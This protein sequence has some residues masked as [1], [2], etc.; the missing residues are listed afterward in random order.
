MTT[1]SSRAY[2]LKL[3]DDGIKLFL[4]C[5]GR[6]CLLVP[7]LLSY[8][9]T[10]YVSVA[11]LSH[12]STEDLIAEVSAEDL[13][14]FGGKEIRFVGTSTQLAQATARLSE[15]IGAS[16]HL[17]PV[18]QSWKIFLAALRAMQSADDK[19]IVRTYDALCASDT[20]MKPRR[21]I[22]AS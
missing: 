11:A 7:E 12:S 14:G 3:S 1:T 6:L 20:G 13:L 21:L 10:L 5:H 8:G 16:G 18:P 15:R 2:K 19:L 9:T 4:R 22:T 17:H